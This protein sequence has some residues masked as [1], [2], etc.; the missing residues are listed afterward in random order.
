[1]LGHSRN[2]AGCS[3][4]TPSLNSGHTATLRSAQI[5]KAISYVCK[6]LSEIGC[7]GLINT[8]ING[9]WKNMSEK[10]INFENKLWKAADKLRKKS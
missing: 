2:L 6:P 1:M 9:R 5:A 7:D 4:L 8:I 10:D 3:E